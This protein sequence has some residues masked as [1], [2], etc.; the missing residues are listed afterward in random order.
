MFSKRNPK[1]LEPYG[2]KF[3]DIKEIT[4]TSATE[5]EFWVH[6]PNEKAHIEE[7]STSEVLQEQY[8]TRT[9]GAVRTALEVN[10]NLNGEVWLRT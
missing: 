3:E 8:W 7:L 9:K 4:T 2:I 10:S 6:T 1:T 5:L